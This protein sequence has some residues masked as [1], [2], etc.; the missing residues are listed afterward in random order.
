LRRFAIGAFM[1][2]LPIA[3][4]T[5]WDHYEA[6]RL[7]RVV[8]D[9]RARNEPVTPTQ[10]IGARTDLPDNAA[11]YYEAAAALVDVRDFYG[12]AGLLNRIDNATEGDRPRIVQEVRALL[13]HNR[14]AEALLARATD[15]PFEGYAPGT[16]YSYRA[17]RLSKLARV[18]NLRT[19]ERLEDR[20][21]E[22]AAQSIVQQLRLNRPLGASG[23]TELSVIGMGWAATPAL[24][25]IARFLAAGPSDASLRHVQK[26]IRELDDDRILERSLLAHR[27]F[28]LGSYWNESRGWFAQ[29]RDMPNGGLFVLMRP[30]LTRQYVQIIGKLT[31]SVERARQPWPARLHIDIVDSPPGSQGRGLW[32]ILPWKPASHS[33][34]TSYRRQAASVGTALALGRTA[35]AAIAAELY[36]RAN[37]GRLP[38]SLAQT[39]PAYLPSVP[40]DP[41]SGNE[42]RYVR[43]ANGSVVYSLGSNEKD[44]GG[45]KIDYPVWRS[46]AF[47][48]RGAPPDLGVAIDF[49]AGPR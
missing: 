7:A 6:R 39:V 43:T 23:P 22:A 49:R 20:N 46:G 33:L 35:D 25:E 19:L 31:E 11:R 4:H 24:R 47:Q 5:A 8:A 13:D 21:A 9:I 16:A 48:D 37:G 41:F 42:L 2:L 45:A 28:M 15:L 34:G 32:S 29:H 10:T 3:L 36:R 14:E 26:A 38:D 30:L 44:D 17:D 40:I 27:A 1:V 12:P 18:A